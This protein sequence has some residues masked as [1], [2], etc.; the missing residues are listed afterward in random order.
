MKIEKATKDILPV[1]K[2][3]STA[4]RAKNKNGK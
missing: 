3:L 1:S 4:I 2:Y